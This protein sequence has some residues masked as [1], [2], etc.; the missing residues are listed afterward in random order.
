MTRRKFVT[1]WLLGIALGVLAIGGWIHGIY[2]AGGINQPGNGWTG[3]GCHGSGFGATCEPWQAVMIDF[4]PFWAAIATIAG[5]FGLYGGA[6]FVEN[7]ARRY[8]ELPSAKERK[9][10]IEAERK[11]QLAWDIARLERELGLAEH[12][13]LGRPFAQAEWEAAMRRRGYTSPYADGEPA[14]Y[15]ERLGP[16]RKRP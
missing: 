4:A 13:E 16:P 5:L 12:P 1:L 3:P 11:A 8:R 10:R 9:A 6:Y 2:W 15:M 14:P 7:V